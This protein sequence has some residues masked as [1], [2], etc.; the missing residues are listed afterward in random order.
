MRID[1][2]ATGGLVAIGA[3]GLLSWLVLGLPGPSLAAGRSSVSA[4]T[5]TDQVSAAEG[6]ALFVQS[7]AS[8]HGV[9][10]R[11]TAAGVSL[12]GV[13]AASADLMLRTGRMPASDPNAPQLAG[14]PAFDDDQIRAL[15]AYVASL[16]EG[17]P[18]PDVQVSRGDVAAGRE[19][20]I[21]SCAACHG[22]GASGDSIGGQAVA[23][24]LLDV[25]PTLVGEAVRTG[26]G[27]MPVFGP[28]QIDDA[29]LDALAAYLAFLRSDEA[30]PGGLSL[31]GVG[32]VTEGYVAWIVGIGLLVLA[33]IWIERRRALPGPAARGSS[34]TGPPRPDDGDGERDLDAEEP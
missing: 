28:E 19:L 26:P 27:V 12:V 34:A 2:Q 6:E 14:K 5:S 8:C 29:G 31:G 33:A 11:G 7:C 24:P 1:R 25:D 23:P 20:F 17:P 13:G 3:I 16:G 30:S 10:G 32:P 21:G 4:T 9:G 15:V 18:I 22:A